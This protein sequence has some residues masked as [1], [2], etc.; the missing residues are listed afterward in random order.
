MCIDC[1]LDEA[2]DADVDAQD[3][4]T[5][6]D[7]FAFLAFFALS[8]PTS[9]DEAPDSRGDV[10][11]GDG[12]CCA[13]DAPSTGLRAM[14]KCRLTLTA[15]SRVAGVEDS[16]SLALRDML[17]MDDS[18]LRLSLALVCDVICARD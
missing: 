13:D 9:N 5:P 11:F 4:S 14:R 15:G 18:E 8:R 1:C 12:T 2:D 17:L 6:L 3:K 7:L 10:G 16:L